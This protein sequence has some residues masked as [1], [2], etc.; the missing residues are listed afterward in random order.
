MSVGA[1]KAYDTR[2]FVETVREMG[3]GRTWRRTVKRS[4]GSAIDGRTTRHASYAVSQ[5]QATAD[6]EGVRMDEADRRHA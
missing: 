1:D 4:G 6:R 3:S 2:D 5:R